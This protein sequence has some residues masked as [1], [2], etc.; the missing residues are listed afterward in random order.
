MLWLESDDKGALSFSLV[1][2]YKEV[3]R[4]GVG[5]QPPSSRVP[6]ARHSLL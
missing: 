1:G 6:E 5:L 3:T 2:A 4:P